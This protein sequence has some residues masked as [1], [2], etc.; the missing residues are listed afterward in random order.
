[1]TV[2]ADATRY[3][4]VVIAAHS[5][6]ALAMLSDADDARARR[7]RRHRLCAQH[8]LPASRRQ[9]DAK[10]PARLGVVEFPALAASR[11]PADN[12]VAVTYWMNRLQGID[13]GK[14]AVRQP[15]SAVR[16]CPGT[17]FRQVH[18]RASAIRRRRLRRPE[19][20]RRD[21]GRAVTPGSAAHGPDTAFTRMAYGQD[22]RWRKRWAPPCRGAARRPNWRRP[23]SNN[24]RTSRQSRD[25]T[26]STPRRR[27]ILAR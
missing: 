11:R 15:Q 24:A 17:D 16:A 22:W 23:R 4:H 6:Q 27:F 3:D 20:P 25:A 10:A 12:D 8:R 13:H 2:T 21:P 14:A 26:T 7:A 18:L 19:T 1:M 9:I 5:D